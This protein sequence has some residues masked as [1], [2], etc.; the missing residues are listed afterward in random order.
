MQVFARGSGKGSGPVGYVTSSLGLVFEP[1]GKIKR[2]AN[3]K[4][5]TYVRIPPPVI[6]AGDAN[7]TIA[8]IDSLDFKYKYTS[9][10]LGFAPENG[11]MTPEKEAEI[12]ADFERVAFAGL[13]K[14]QYSIL[15]VRHSHQG[16]HELHFIVPRVELSTGKS[17]NI[18]PPNYQ[19][20]FD[21]WRSTWNEREGWADPD[22]PARA[23]TVAVP[24][25]TQK[26][27][28]S[29]LR[30]GIV[31]AADPRQVITDYLFSSI[32]I[33]S[34]QDR[35]GVIAALEEAG[36][37]INR[38]GKDHISVR[39]EPGA[40]PIRLKGEIYG[41]S[42]NSIGFSRPI[43]SENRARPDTNRELGSGR[44]ETLERELA[45]AVERRA[46]FNRSRYHPKGGGVEP[47]HRGDLEHSP[48][49]C[50]RNEGALNLGVDQADSDR[51]E[52][53]SG[54][55]GWQL[56]P[57]AVVFERHTEPARDAGG[58]GQGDRSTAGDIGG[59]SPTGREDQIIELP[60]RSE[61]EA[62]RA[63][64]RIGANVPEWLS[65]LERILRG[66]YDR[67]REAI[68]RSIE[69]A[70]RA[71]RGGHEA[72]RHADSELI[73]T[74]AIVERSV[75]RAGVVKVKREDELER[76]K[77]GINLV[78]YAASMG[79]QLD[80]K[81]SSRN[82]KV[83]ENGED[84]IVIATGK[85][86]HGIYFSVTDDTDCGSIID[87]IQR[88]QRLNLGQ[89][90]RALRKWE[91]SDRPIPEKSL[92]K[93]VPSEKD[94][95]QVIAVYAKAASGIPNYIVKN[96]GIDAKTIKDPRF[97][98]VVRVDAHRNAIFPHFNESGLC[99]YELKN[100]GFTGFAKGGQK[101]LWYT[102][103]IIRAD[104][105]VICESAIDALSHAQVHGDSD[106]AYVS[107]AGTMNDR[108]PELI[109]QIFKNAASR[110][111]R[112]VLATDND[113][114]GN[115]LVQQMTE[116]AKEA[117][118]A[119]TID[120]PSGGFKDWNECLMERQRQ[121]QLSVKPQR[122]QERGHGM[123]R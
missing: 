56:G 1:D 115:R 45:A 109:R 61:K 81:S 110:G 28:S 51:G 15:W 6:V 99:G 47:E 72:A 77:T 85:T 122:L 42:F 94:I 86:G 26:I 65:N 66:V 107:I 96:R 23:R 119:C 11:A 92:E 2:D 118:A 50:R 22:D 90:R 113:E 84:K 62:L 24:D 121:E 27:Q 104:K 106:A 5:E 123:E 48:S 34:I 55:L 37:E 91:G 20:F 57:D 102:S 67:T 88:R 70:V 33:G 49:E 114:T 76:F 10:V 63:D 71:I 31:A 120:R 35:T 14:D 39:P 38:Q 95:Q 116:W 68:K 30:A 46:E 32:E 19:K 103:N 59:F 64:Q 78:E 9:G 40:K 13:D 29:N 43:E 41:E 58:L 87:F 53:L 98:S 89:V 44:I 75:E 82:S 74:S 36:L 4:P 16:H 69:A 97:A 54:Y 3:S 21:P 101:G 79:Y 73:K 111:A 8:L 60:G 80:K 100:E 83:M 108:Q 25:H 52:S 93:P 7:N 12:I 105:I 18:C 17:L 117:G 112:V